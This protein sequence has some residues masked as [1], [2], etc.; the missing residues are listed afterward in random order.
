MFADAAELWNTALQNSIEFKLD[1]AGAV[2]EAAFYQPD[3][4]YLAKRLR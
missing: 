4:T 1:A 3:G 2:S